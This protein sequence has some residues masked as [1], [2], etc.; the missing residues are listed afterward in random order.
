MKLATYL[1][2]NAVTQKDFAEQIGEK[3]PIINLYCRRKRIPRPDVMLKIFK[4]TNG[5]V[6]PN[7]FYDICGDD[8]NVPALIKEGTDYA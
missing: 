6:T 3:Q 1:A 7:D 5:A 8:A 4:A 2:T